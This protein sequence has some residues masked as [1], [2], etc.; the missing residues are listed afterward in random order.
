MRAQPASRRGLF[1]LLLL[2]GLF[3]L[4]LVAAVVTAASSPAVAS[5]LGGVGR[6]TVTP[7]APHFALADIPKPTYTPLPTATP[8]ETSTSLP[9]PTATPPLLEMS[10]VDT[11]SLPSSPVEAAPSYTGSKY[12]L[13]DISEQHMYVYENEQLIYSF[14][15]STGINNSTRT[16]VFHVQSKYPN[17][18]GATWNIWMPSWLGIYYTG[19]LENGIHALPI[20]PGG[21]ELW[22]GYLGSPVSYGCVVLGSYEAGVLYNWAEIG[23]P[24]EIQW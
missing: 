24:V 12:I 9:T 3:F 16:G 7:A 20:L 19:G 15:A 23:T 11:S 8:F 17:A 2:L 14:V 6:L 10:I 4:A 18:Y 21:G 1:Y 5:I 13:V 22:A